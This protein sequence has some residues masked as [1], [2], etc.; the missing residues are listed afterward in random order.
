MQS[1]V[2][3]TQM[4]AL[5]ILLYAFSDCWAELLLGCS[6]SASL[7]LV[8]QTDLQARFGLAM[9]CYVVYTV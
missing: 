4:L 8:T 7:L 1:H 9:V 3:V 5:T 2:G 6:C